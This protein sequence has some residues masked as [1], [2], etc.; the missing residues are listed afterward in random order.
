M[1]GTLSVESSPG[2]GS[3]FRIS[4]PVRPLRESLLPPAP[5]SSPTT[6][7]VHGAAPLRVLVIDDELLIGRFVQ[8]A[9]PADHVEFMVDP[10]E[11]L[12]RAETLDYD[13][14]LCDLRM[15]AMSG[16]ALFNALMA[17]RPELSQRF[18]LMSGASADTELETFLMEQ[19]V[20]VLRKPFPLQTLR[21][22][23]SERRSQARP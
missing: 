1:G 13:V 16:I 15:P 4:L 22:L 20:A 21:A 10:S 8:A 14:I 19:R 12:R 18:V 3:T 6:R 17:V 2:A 9:L 7:D 23:L 5:E 11:V